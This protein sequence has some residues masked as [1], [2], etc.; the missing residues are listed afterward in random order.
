[1]QFPEGALE[2]LHPDCVD[3]CRNLLRHNPGTGYYCAGLCAL[4][5][6]VHVKVIIVQQS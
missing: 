6:Y 2:E 3:L 1:M 4:C 5:I